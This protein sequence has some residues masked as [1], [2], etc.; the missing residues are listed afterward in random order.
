[1]ETFFIIQDKSRHSNLFM[2]FLVD[3]RTEA[4]NLYQSH[5]LWICAD[6]LVIS[7]SISIEYKTVD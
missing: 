6:L 7:L 1:M 3:M 2:I 5:Q 4:P